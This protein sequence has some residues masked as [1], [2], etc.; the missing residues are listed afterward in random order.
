MIPDWA[1]NVHPLIVHFP[2]ALLFAA[3]LVDVVSLGIRRQYPA[4]RHAAVGLY[5]LGA[6][7]AVVTFFTGRSASDGVDLPVSAVSAV[8]AHSD[9]ALWVV[10][11]FGLYALVR[12]GVAFWKRGGDLVVHLPLALVGV[13]A[14]F[15]VQ[16]TAERG[17]KLVYLYGVGVQAV[18]IE[19]PTRHDHDAHDMG[20]GAGDDDSDGDH[21]YGGH[22]HDGM[23][24]DDDHGGGTETTGT[25]DV[26]GVPALQ[27]VSGVRPDGATLTAS[28]G[29]PAFV[30]TGGAVGDLEAQASLDL[31]G[32]TGTA[33]LVHHVRDAQ[34]YDFLAVDKPVEGAATVRQ[35]RVE[36]GA[37]TTFDDGT[38]TLSGPVV[39]KTY[40]VGTHFR[41]YV[42]GEQ[43][44]HG[45][46]DAAP[47]GRVGL[48]LDGQGSVRVL[49]LSATPVE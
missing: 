35:G 33:M 24:M 34:N 42:G 28:P 1:P 2:I 36:G 21:A 4:V 23:D 13:A 3:A 27:V 44:T 11:V 30:T 41:G 31:S 6:V 19:N 22:D 26:G 25:A 17:A 14:L 49:A 7:A 37:E 46:G 5:V 15:L 12:L 43:V 18:E 38:A 10:W 39:L 8:N 47:A 29:R 16:Q 20:A 9:W 32:F 45:H 48:R 40:A